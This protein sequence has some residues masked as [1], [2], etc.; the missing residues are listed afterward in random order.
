[1]PEKPLGWS[2]QAGM[3]GPLVV[4][5]GAWTQVCDANDRR[6]ALILSA[7]NGASLTYSMHTESTAAD[8]MTLAV[9][10]HPIVLS[11][12]LHGGLVTRAW[13]ARS[14]GFA[15]TIRVFEALA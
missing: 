10:Q 14:L 13:F 2:G 7:G 4:D 12:A 1:M 3:S 6:I 9:G 8:G 5:S 15:D 11:R